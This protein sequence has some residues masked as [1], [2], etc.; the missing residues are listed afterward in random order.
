M[1]AAPCLGFG[2]ER[3]FRQIQVF[4]GQEMGG[5]AQNFAVVQD[6]T[7]MIYVG[8]LHG[9]LEFDGAT[10][11]LIELPMQTAVNTLVQIPDGRK[12]AGGYNQVGFLSQDATH[13]TRFQSIKDWIPETCRDFGDI[14]TF[15]A[16][17]DRAFMLTS[18]FLFE[19]AYSDEHLIPHPRSQDTHVF[20]HGNTVV[21]VADGGMRV[22]GTTAPSLKIPP[23]GGIRFSLGDLGFLRVD[24][25]V[26][27]LEPS[28]G[29]DAGPLETE[30]EHVRISAVEPLEDG[31]F[32]IATR[33]KGILIVD[34]RLRI[35]EVLDVYTGLPDN[36]VRSIHASRDGMLWIALNTGLAAI[37]ISSNVFLF[38]KRHGIESQVT[39]ITRYRDTLYLG[40]SGGIFSLSA[41]NPGDESRTTSPIWRARR[42]TPQRIGVWDFIVTDTDELAIGTTAGVLILGEDGVMPVP[43]TQELVV[44]QFGACDTAPGTIFLGTWQGLGVLQHGDGQWR[45]VG[46]VPES[47]PQIRAI[48][49]TSDGTVW[50]GTTFDGAWRI[51][52]LFDQSGRVHSG[53]ELRQIGEGEIQ[54]FLFQNDLAF[55]QDNQFKCLSTDGSAL[56]AHPVLTA[57]LFSSG[58]FEAFRDARGAYW[59]NTYP[60]T[61]ITVTP[62]QTLK[63]DNHTYRNV[64]AFDVQRFFSDPDGT[65]WLTSQDGVVK[66]ERDAQPWNPASFPP[67]IGRVTYGSDPLPIQDPNRLPELQ[68]APK[69]MR[70]EFAPLDFRPNPS[71]Q[72]RMDPID[73]TWSPWSARP[74]VEY[75][76][77][78]EG[79]YHFRMRMKRPDRLFSPETSFSFRIHPPW[80]RTVV[81]YC[82]YS[83]ALFGLVLTVAKWRSRQLHRQAELLRFTVQS[84][85]RQLKDLLVDLRT[86]KAEVEEKNEELRTK[87]K[88]LSE[89]SMVDGL[90]GVANRRRMDEF[91]A[92]EWKRAWRL[93]TPTSVILLDLDHF[94]LLNDALGH[95]EGDECLKNVATYL[96]QLKLR[97]SDLVARYGGE[98]FVIILSNCA[99][100]DAQKLAEEMRH[101]I[102]NLEL[103][104]PE[105]PFSRV[106][107]SFGVACMIADR[108]NQPHELLSEADRALYQAKTRGRNRVFGEPIR[109]DGSP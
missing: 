32:L 103:P 88:V 86:A 102:E 47:P 65:L 61:C 45:F 53:A 83:L 99:R 95:L 42:V 97:S 35:D 92:Q 51:R 76:N 108:A 30:L 80:Y 69:R 7:G 85:T 38:D 79:T 21:L 82:V 94:K 91:L 2:G 36:D 72:Y 28:T 44:Y 27:L 66:I 101:G 57:D 18:R 67:R 15:C 12:L 4:S 93:Q 107:A 6:A 20:L 10:W 3:G 96:K 49:Q 13:A 50:L 23:D 25:R 33:D 29:L 58:F 16:T 73:V 37:D 106:T 1:V 68:Y 31:R 46:M 87:N 24:G 39:C 41:A 22:L 109:S 105:S 11:N 90:T 40:T 48:Q 5:G 71:F 84:Q 77:L 43:G 64:P 59:V 74:F 63:V 55:I 54:V 9:V 100:M 104:H 19:W 56:V 75:T 34:R 98:E 17:P 8:N 89:L 70:I 62:D 14:E 52:G 78:W 26:H 60:L 81:A